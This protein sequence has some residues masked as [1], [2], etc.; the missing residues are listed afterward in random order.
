MNETGRGTTLLGSAKVIIADDHPSVC[1]AVSHVV[2]VT[3]GDHARFE[4][5]GDSDDLLDVLNV[6]DQPCDVLVL[7]LHMPGRFQRLQLIDEVL[8]AQP[9]ARVLVY[10]A[11]DSPH[12]AKAAIE[13]GAAG[14]VFKGR[15][16]KTLGTAIVEV[17]GGRQFVD[18]GR[19]LADTDSHPWGLLTDSERR[20]LRQLAAGRAVK[21]IAFAS[22]R[23]V[24]TIHT[25]KDSGLSKLGLRD[26]A[27]LRPFM[28]DEG[29]D[30]ELD[31]IGDDGEQASGR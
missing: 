13:R 6:E 7:D 18:I 24:T 30:F 17:M 8:R 29:L 22:G 19:S 20:V 3:L 16:W 1:F 11:S 25:Q 4:V 9:E 23:S 12:M 28:Y 27:E 21:E 26:V 10:S 2:R 31:A 5:F 15:A 14:Y